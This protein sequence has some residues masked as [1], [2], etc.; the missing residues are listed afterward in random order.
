[1]LLWQPLSLQE[2]FGYMFTSLEVSLESCFFLVNKMNEQVNNME[3]KVSKKIE[4]WE[5]NGN[6]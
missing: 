3:E 4:V 6:E 5:E 2:S 1:M